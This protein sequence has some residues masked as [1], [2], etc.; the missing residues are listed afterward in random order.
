[1][2]CPDL[3]GDLSTIKSLKRRFGVRREEKGK[4][5]AFSQILIRLMP[6][7]SFLLVSAT[8][9]LKDSQIKTVLSAL[10]QIDSAFC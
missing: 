6:S 4:C 5:M 3:L 9:R 2:G 1:M 10:K 7:F 8:N